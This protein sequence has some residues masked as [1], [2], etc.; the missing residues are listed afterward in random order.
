VKLV[1]GEHE[2]PVPDMSGITLKE[3]RQIKAMI[4]KPLSAL[5]HDDEEGVPKLDTT[6]PDVIS[7]IIW[8]AMSRSDPT[9]TFDDVDSIVISDVSVV[10][11]ASDEGDASPPEPGV[12]A[13]EPDASDGPGTSPSDDA[14]APDGSV[15]SNGS[16]SESSGSGSEESGRETTLEASGLPGS[17]DGSP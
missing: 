16:G 15:I 13:P 3:Q 1:I 9:V 14:G 6:D 2:Y 12:T 5:I 4:G 7:A 17:S 10:L 11:D 8:F